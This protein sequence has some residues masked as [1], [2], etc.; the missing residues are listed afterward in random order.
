MCNLSANSWH[1]RVAGRRLIL[2]AAIS[3]SCPLVCKP[4]FIR[5]STVS[6]SVSPHSWQTGP[7]H[8]YLLSHFS[9]S[10]W[11]ISSSSCMSLHPPL[12]HWLLCSGSVFYSLFSAD[13]CD[14]PYKCSLFPWSFPLKPFFFPVS[15][16]AVWLVSCYF[17]FPNST[18]TSLC[19]FLTR[20]YLQPIY[21]VI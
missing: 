19:A 20:I 12:L 13:W 10:H 16:A 6:Q 15:N 8:I 9:V 18:S 1:R 11:V 14:L 17:R 3:L 5:L 4:F 7:K 2:N 21:A